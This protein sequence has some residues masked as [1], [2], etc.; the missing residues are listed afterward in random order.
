MFVGHFGAGLTD[1]AFFT[2]SLF[3]IERFRVDEGLMALSDFDLMHMPWTHSLVATFGWAAL[4]G[5]LVGAVLRRP[6]VGW[7][8]A[9]VVISHWALDLLV[10]RPDLT[11][12]GS[13][14]KFGFGLWD[15]PAV[16]IPLEFAILLGGAWLYARAVPSAT[17]AGRIGLWLL[18]AALVGAQLVNWFAE[19]ATTAPPLLALQA[20]AVFAV[21]TLAGWWVDR[22][23]RRVPTAAG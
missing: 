17:R 7:V 10:H 18:V 19:P 23:R 22:A 11:L 21:V 4:F 8:A 6:A 5:L 2:F 14:P 1:Y 3:G 12:T 16:G 20:L 9:A 13:P 15:V